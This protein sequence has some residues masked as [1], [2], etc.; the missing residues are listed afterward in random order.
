MKKEEQ[1]AINA[2]VEYA[3]ECYNATTKSGDLKTLSFTHMS[4]N[5]L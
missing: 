1:R 3:I 5:S 4:G 2:K